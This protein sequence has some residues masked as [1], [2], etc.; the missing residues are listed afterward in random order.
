MATD[1]KNER[2]SA[3]FKALAVL[4]AVLA[5]KRPIGL[6]DIAAE[7]DLPRQTVH[8]VLQQLEANG[9][10]RRDLSRDRFLVGPAMTRLGLAALDAA[11]HSGPSRLI[12]QG[13]VDE[14]GET[15]NVGVL[16]GR[17]VIYID[18]VECDWPL[19]VQLQAGSRVPAHCT[20]IGKLLLA[21]LARGVRQRLLRAAPL[22]RYTERTLADPEVLEDQFARIRRQGYSTND[23]EYSVG[24]IG[25]AVPIFDAAG[26]PV[27]ALA[28]HA[29]VVRLSLEAGLAHLPRLHATAEKLAQ[30][31]GRDADPGSAA[32]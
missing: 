12:L 29:P 32:A 1:G 14:L 22:P 3:L 10:L 17:E 13:L 2:G 7:V 18:R 19:R 15:C 31:F 6:P 11:A 20:S 8:R 25:I 26:K 24:M 21:H 5:Q 30:A 16:E 9:L 4:E 27:A 23:Q 28:V